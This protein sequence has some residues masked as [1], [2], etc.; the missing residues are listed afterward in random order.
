MKNGNCKI[1]KIRMLAITMALIIPCFAIAL[2]GAVK[3]SYAIE[4]GAVIGPYEDV[5]LDHDLNCQNGIALTVVGPATLNMKGHTLYGKLRGAGILV[6]G[7][8]AKVMN[9][10]VDGFGDG[11]VVLGNGNHHISKITAAKNV[12]NGFIVGSSN[13]KFVGNTA[14]GNVWEGFIVYTNKNKLVNN[15]SV[16]NGGAGFRIMGT[17]NKLVNN[18]T[19]NNSGGGIEVARDGN[20]LKNNKLETTNKKHARKK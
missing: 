2:E 11:V 6:F 13:N 18:K 1:K 8:G 12:A 15:I 4:C 10:S 5:T 14:D 7:E 20:T 9:G 19:N 3:P 17:R 16:N